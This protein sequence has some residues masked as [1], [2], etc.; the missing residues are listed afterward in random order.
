MQHLKK[1][2]KTKSHPIA[3]LIVLLLIIATIAYFAI[4]KLTGM[5]ETSRQNS[6]DNDAQ[7]LVRVAQAWLTQQEVAEIIPVIEQDNHLNEG[8]VKQI[9]AMA[10]SIDQEVASTVVVTVKGSQ[11]PD[12]YQLAG[13]KLTKKGMTATVTK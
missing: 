12:C 13:V 6:A 3:E 7:I 11:I 8:D 1:K 2:K 5:L 4:P 9:V 10:D